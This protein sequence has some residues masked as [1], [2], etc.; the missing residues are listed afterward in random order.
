MLSNLLAVVCI[1]ILIGL[2][3]GLF[4]ATI[5]LTQYFYHDLTNVLQQQNFDDPRETF[6][7]ILDY[8][9]FMVIWIFCWPKIILNR[10]FPKWI[11]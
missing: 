6:K 11:D 10:K 5:Q 8:I 9:K 4:A 2:I 1:Y 7:K 3:L